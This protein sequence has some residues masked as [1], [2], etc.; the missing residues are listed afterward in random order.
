[1]KY[2]WLKVSEESLGRDQ[3]PRQTSHEHFT[4]IKQMIAAK[5]TG[6]SF[7]RKAYSFLIPRVL[8]LTAR[9][10]VTTLCRIQIN[11]ERNIAAPDKV[12][13][14]PTQLLNIYCILNIDIYQNMFTCIVFF[15]VTQ[16]VSN[17]NLILCFNFFFL[18]HRNMEMY[19]K[20]VLFYFQVCLI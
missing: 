9:D 6:G 8:S 5:Q 11:K 18:I 12:W 4:N 15:C 10:H 3:T 17:I 19:G 2:S 14:N 13:G 16:Y 7:W 1:M 20:S